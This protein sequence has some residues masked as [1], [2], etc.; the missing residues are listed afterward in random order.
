MR[1]IHTVTSCFEKVDTVLRLESESCNAWRV[2]LH[3]VQVNFRGL[4]RL[5]RFLLCLVAD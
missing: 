2:L 1:P 3:C 4:K 5:K